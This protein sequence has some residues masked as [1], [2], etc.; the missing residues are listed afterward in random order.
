MIIN[1]Y[2]DFSLSKAGICSLE[3][4]FP[5]G[6]YFKLDSDIRAVFPY[7]NRDA[8]GVRYFEQPEYLQ[9]LFEA[10]YTTLYPR[11]VLAAPFAGEEQAILFF[12]NLTRYI[13]RLYEN[14]SRTEPNHK[15]FRPVSVVD[16]LKL[17]PRTNCRACG[18]TTCMAFAAALRQGKS[19]PDHCP[20]FEKPITTHA[21]YPVFDPGGRLISTVTLEIDTD[22]H[23][24]SL[25]QVNRPADPEIPIETSSAEPLS[26]APEDE[27]ATADSVLTDREIQ[28]LRLI[29]KG[30]TNN[31]ISG[32]LAI[33]PHT[34]KSHVIHIF[35]KLGVSDR[36][37]A[38][39]SAIR[40]RLI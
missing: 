5:W 11:E 3:T 24:A 9:F 12:S 33:S 40:H 18:F 22:H 21:V 4:R 8:T 13:N 27:T 15:K 10:C 26:A 25:G 20:G 14:R 16:V 37:Q 29:A 32:I 31:A 1:G 23:P 39:V 19:S 30:E 17:L 34:V 7:I 6:A 35:N 36:T 2:T 38:S 28:V